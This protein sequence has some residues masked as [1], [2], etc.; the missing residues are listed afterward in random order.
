M[1]I[2]YLSDLHL[3]FYKKNFDFN[4][5]FNFKSGEIGDILCLCG[6]IGYPEMQNY[7]DFIDFCSKYFKYVFIISG[8]HEYYSLKN[9]NKTI[10]NTNE[11]IETI[12][13]KYTNVHFLNN[14]TIY[15]EECDMHIIGSTLWVEI[16]DTFDM[17][18]CPFNDF[19]NIYYNY[20]GA[21]YKL[22]TDFMDLMYFESVEFLE[23]ELEKL[24]DTKSKVIIL[25]HHLPS[26]K[27]IAPKYKSNPTN[28]LYA[29][30]LDHFFDKFKINYWLSGHSH[31]PNNIKLNNTT[32][33]L[34]P[35][36]YPGELLEPKF[37]EY[38]NL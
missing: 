25:T 2:N 20:D 5:L 14:K 6:D 18:K 34:N 32:L 19:K 37:N 1:K 9:N 33:L 24:K 13:K 7:S 27:L 16:D 22:N 29:S 30:N 10:Q 26:F 36:G 17:S 8:N 11:L 35:I 12:C 15:L 4:K 31:S 38:F 3:E 23:E 21:K 28:F